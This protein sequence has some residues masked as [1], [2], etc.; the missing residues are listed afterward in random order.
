MHHKFLIIDGKKVWTGSMNFQYN[1]VY[2]NN[3]N[4]IL[5]ES[6]DLAANYQDE[7]EEMFTNREFT[8]RDNSYEPV[9]VKLDTDDGTVLIET[10]FSPENGVQ[11]EERLVEL[12]G[13]ARNSVRFMAFSFTLDDLGGAMI[14]AFDDGVTVEGVFETTGSKTD[15]SEMTKMLCAGM[16]VKQDGN[17][18]VLHHKVII[19]DS[20]I[21]AFG[22]FNFSN[23]ARDNNSENILIVHSPE[24]AE[25]YETEFER[26]YNDPRAEMLPDDEY[27]CR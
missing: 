23:S 5:I 18:D 4:A 13:E 24:L 26:I 2:N 15:D 17:P 6:V 27:S 21:V 25:Q 11:I 8:R 22:S 16:S 3:N 19:I 20:E 14:S 12:I 7:F 9:E 1:D 10:Y